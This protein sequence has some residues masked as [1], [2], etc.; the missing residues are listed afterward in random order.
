MTSGTISHSFAEET[1]QGKAK[2]FQTLS[3]EE[4]MEMLCTFTDFIL[5][6]NPTIADRRD[7]ESTATRI[8]ILTKA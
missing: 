7:A 5:S 1:P 4:R 8:R 3:I 6:M 2:W